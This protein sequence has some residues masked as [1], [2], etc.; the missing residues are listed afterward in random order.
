MEAP[1]NTINDFGSFDADFCGAP[2]IA[3]P[4]SP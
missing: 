2:L 1:N 3:I 4:D